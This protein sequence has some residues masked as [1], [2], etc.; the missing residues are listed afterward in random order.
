[1]CDSCPFFGPSP[2]SAS[3]C[4]PNKLSTRFPISSKS[5]IQF[6]CISLLF[7]IRFDNPVARSSKLSSTGESV[8]S[9]VVMEDFVARED[10]KRVLEI[11][12]ACTLR[13]NKESR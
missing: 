4:S 5:S 8:D 2:A 6:F 3:V 12:S 11:S 1:M 9:A 10:C 7:I 13:A